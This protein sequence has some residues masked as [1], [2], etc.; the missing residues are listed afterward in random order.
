VKHSRKLL[1][2]LGVFLLA[3][4]LMAQ[5]DSLIT[6]TVVPGQPLD[7]PV[8]A[9]DGL[10]L[11]LLGK[12][13][14]LLAGVFNKVLPPNKTLRE[15]VAIVICGGVGVLVAFL[16][17]QWQW[18]KVIFSL[19]VS[20]ASGI[21]WYLKYW[22]PRWEA[23]KAPVLA[24]IPVAPVALPTSVVIPIP[25]GLATTTKDCPSGNPDNPYGS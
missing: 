16:T 9:L 8:W 19:L 22:R 25:P 6:H 14:S 23:L 21:A 15:T 11:I 3:G 5:V 2:L 20:Y 7:I 10:G 1:T 13:M 4:L 18:H 17:G 12:F 24:A